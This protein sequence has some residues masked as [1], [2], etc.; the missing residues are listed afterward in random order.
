M[1]SCNKSDPSSSIPIERKDI[2]LTKSQE[3]V[4][5]QGNRFGFDMFREMA[6][7]N[8]DKNFLVSPLS[9]AQVLAALSCGAKGETLSQMKDALGFTDMEAAQMN[10]FYKTLVPALLKVDNTTKLSLANAL[11]IRD[12]FPVEDAFVKEV[13]TNYY[14]TAKRLDFSSPNAVKTINKWCADNTNNLIPEIIDKIGPYDVLYATNALYFKGIWATPF[15]ETKTVAG[16]FKGATGTQSAR[17]MC[18]TN[19]FQFLS[20]DYGDI[21][22]FP[23][24]NQAFRMAVLL[25]PE[26][27][28]PYKLAAKLTQEQWNQW[29]KDTRYATLDVRLPRFKVAFD[30]EE[31]LISVMQKLGMTTAF[32]Q[33][34][35]FTRITP[36]IGLWI[37]LLKQKT[38]I[39]VNEEGTEAAA[40]TIG[41]IRCTSALPGNDPIP[42]HVNR[43]FIYVIEEVSTGTLLFMGL[44]ANLE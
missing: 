26:G 15:E 36:D 22:F 13:A 5:E 4:L 9:A 41:G 1:N 12:D 34:A 44:N 20:N 23:Y 10:D 19:S 30:S 31:Q 35:D 42:F 33:N 43:P 32:T 16:D 6:A 27:V 3:Q 11:W 25:P 14:S 7:V 21:A 38:Y 29:R 2:A 24:G 37:N 17:Y 39:E 40:V 18:Q 8:P 28:S